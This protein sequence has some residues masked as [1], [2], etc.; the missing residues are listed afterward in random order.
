MSRDPKIIVALDHGDEQ[1]IL[2]LAKQLDPH[3]CRIKIGSILFTEYGPALLEKIKQLGFAIFLDLKFHDIPQ[4]VAGAC[5]AAAQLGVWMVNIHISGGLEMMI[6]AREAIE[7]VPAERRPLLIGVSILTSLNDHDLKTLGYSEPVAETVLHFS[8]L[9]QTAR[10]DGLVCSAHELNLLRKT[11]PD[12][13][14]LVV[15]GIRLPE[16]ALGGQKRVMTPEQAFRA[17]ADYLVIGRPFTQSPNP[18]QLLTMLTRTTAG[19]KG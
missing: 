3:L 14:L 19:R 7:T 18:H 1:T 12:H 9:A 4:T 15:P 11:V 17:G 13:F 10:L 8:Q 5:R 16:D 2:N 6:A